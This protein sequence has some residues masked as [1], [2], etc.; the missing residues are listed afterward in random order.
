MEA[1]RL[2]HILDNRMTKEAALKELVEVAKL[3]KRCLGFTGR[4][5]PTMKE[6]AAVLEDLRSSH[7]HP[8][9]PQNSLAGDI[10]EPSSRSLHN[11]NVQESFSLVASFGIETGSSRE[12]GN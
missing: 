2:F 6:V 11:A 5:R 3:A 10:A 7:G 8:S 9:L 12:D 4:E 1:N